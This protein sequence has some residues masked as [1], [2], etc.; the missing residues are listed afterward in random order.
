M[1]LLEK[2]K[3]AGY[4]MGEYFSS[5]REHGYSQLYILNPFWL[6]LVVPLMLVGDP[7]YHYMI[8]SA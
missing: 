4:K 8:D 5:P 6:R 1:I 2:C 3:C 7:V